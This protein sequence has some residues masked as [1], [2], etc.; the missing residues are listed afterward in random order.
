MNEYSSGRAALSDKSQS[1]NLLLVTHRYIKFSLP[2]PPGMRP[3]NWL[4]Y[5]RRELQVTND[6]HCNTPTTTREGQNASSY[7]SMYSVET[8]G[9]VPEN[10]FS[11]R[12][13]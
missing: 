9:N 6:A 13:M 7:P 2:G 1:S 11:D 5:S 8:S 4:L 3:V 12:S 10:M